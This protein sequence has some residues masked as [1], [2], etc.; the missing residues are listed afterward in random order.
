MK[1]MMIA[2]VAAAVASG[3][4][5]A[6]PAVFARSNLV[7]WCIVPFDTKN[8]SPA[9]RAEMVKRLGF[10]KV[11]YDWRDQHVPSFDEE[12]V[13]YRKHGLEYF[14]F[15]ASHEK[16]FELFAKY[17]LHPQIWQTAPSPEGATQADRVAAAVKQLLP[18]VERTAKMKCKLGLYNHGGWGGEPDNLVA[19]CKA[20]HE[21]HHAEHVGIVYNLHHGRG[22]IDDFPQ[23]LAQMKPYLL[24]LN[25]NGTSKDGPQI[26]QLGAGEADVTVLKA[27]VDS[28]YTGP[29]GILGHT[30]EDVEL[31]L[32]D[33]LDGLDW[34]LP[35]LAG[36]P[37]GPRP[38]YR[39]K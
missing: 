19:V 27:I 15:W 37:P 8:R 10:T 28:G 31:R 12:I 20:L 17:D 26:L 4:R 23:S 5:A 36:K 22:H 9:E 29:I 3:A 34:L 35:Q 25:I 24:C 32:R 38:K 39:T 30:H 11:A 6:E 16:A 18:L 7:A 13:Q 14:A 1:R 21:Q 33:N 2:I